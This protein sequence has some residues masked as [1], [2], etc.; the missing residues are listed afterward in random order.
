MKFGISAALLAGS[1]ACCSIPSSANIL[2][3][4]WHGGATVSSPQAKPS[5]VQI[6]DEVVHMDVSPDRYSTKASYKLHNTSAKS[7]HFPMGFS[8]NWPN[9]LGDVTVHIDGKPA[10]VYQKGVSLETD[11][12]FSGQWTVWDITFAPGQSKSVDVSYSQPALGGSYDGQEGRRIS[13]CSEDSFKKLEP[14]L[15][16]RTASYEP[17][18]PRFWKEPAIH[19]HC[20]LTVSG[21]PMA[22]LR[23]ISTGGKKGP[24]NTITWDLR[25]SK[26]GG[27]EITYFPNRATDGLVNLIRD[28]HKTEPDDIFIAMDLAD[29]LAKNGET[30]ERY[31]LYEEC[32]KLWKKDYTSGRYP[33]YGECFNGLVQMGEELLIHLDRT[34]QAQQAREIAPIVAELAKDRGQKKLSIEAKERLDELCR[35]YKQ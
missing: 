17:P 32:L 15:R 2:P 3:F 20:E 14:F 33:A 16:Y 10:R 29:A 6:V 23:S 26:E 4:E 31:Q 30:A 35:K 12:R 13:L 34:G 25:N 27:F 22:N 28:L 9:G 21:I 7:T 18:V 8:T 1:L 19:R 24:N 5:Q 11:D